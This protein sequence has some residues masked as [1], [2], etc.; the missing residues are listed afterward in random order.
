M[1]VGEGEHNMG[2]GVLRVGKGRAQYWGWGVSEGGS[3]IRG[4]ELSGFGR[5]EHN[6][7]E[8][9]SFGRGSTIRGLGS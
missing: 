6:T 9:R 4:W 5:G 2:V 3:I 8:L 1:G 7:G